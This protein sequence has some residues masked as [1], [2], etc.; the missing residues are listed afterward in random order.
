MPT[1][2]NFEAK[3][4][5]KYILDSSKLKD[6]IGA[7]EQIEYMCCDNGLLDEV[8]RSLDLDSQVQF[9]RK[10]GG[11][12]IA[13]F[14]TPADA[15]RFQAVWTF[16]VQK[17]L[18]GLGFA[19]G[20]GT[21]ASLKIAIKIA[22]EAKDEDDHNVF[23]PSLP[24]TGPL[25]ARSPRTGQPAVSRIKKLNERVDATTDAKREFRNGTLLIDKLRFDIPVDWPINLDKKD[26]EGDE[27]KIFPLLDDN[28]YIAIIH[29]DANN[30]GQL[31]KKLQ[32]KLTDDQY[33]QPLTAFSQAVESATVESA[34]KAT[35]DVLVK[36]AEKFRIMPARPLVLGGD[37]V[38]FIVRGDLALDF[39]KVFLEEFEKCSKGK[40]TELKKDYP[41]LENSLP[42]QLTACAG[43]AYVKASQ[44]F[45]QGYNLADSLCKYAKKI[46]KKYLDKTKLVPSSLAFHRMM[47]NNMVK[48]ETVLKDELTIGK[49][50]FQLTMQPYFV[51]EVEPSARCRECEKKCHECPKLKDLCEFLKLLKK[52]EV[53]HG[54]FREF[55]SLLETNPEQAKQAIQRWYDNMKDRG[56]AKLL[57]CFKHILEDLIKHPD[58]KFE[59]S[60]RLI[61]KQK[62]TP[63]G[64]A[65]VLLQI[66]KG[67]DYVPCD[68]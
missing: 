59:S 49:N 21:D 16:C 30:L 67:S 54:T 18:P 23:F 63:I 55:L 12:F 64:D 62:C 37:D 34:K 33:I 6:M 19:Q 32:G 24:L 45:Y 14:S 60:L 31:L 51:G 28:N 5:Q 11:T 25:I 50:N 39:T 3:S 15:K 9:A 65:L 20:M 44:P 38:T 47:N 58:K 57:D 4:I 35:K 46:S 61:D 66:S 7:S 68:F 10:A 41:A 17:V 13:I 42:E 22:R 27:E 2:Y 8:L 56:K 29:A 52:P 43:I 53:S 1:I 36:E 26:K 40:L 48:Y